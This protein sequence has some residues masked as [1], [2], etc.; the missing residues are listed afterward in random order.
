MLDNEQAEKSL[1][2]G[3]Q[4]YHISKPL[5]LNIPYFECSKL[6]WK[7]GKTESFKQRSWGFSKLETVRGDV[8]GER[9]FGNT[10]GEYTDL[11]TQWIQEEK[12]DIYFF[13][14]QL[15]LVVIL[16]QSEGEVMSAHWNSILSA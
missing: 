12:G 8:D 9:P 4:S 14:P 3:I 6:I 7:S 11:F 2:F 1:W 13:K 5:K 16:L 15:L 10:L